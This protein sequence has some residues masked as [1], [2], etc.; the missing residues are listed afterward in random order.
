MNLRTTKWKMII[1]GLTAGLLESQ[2]T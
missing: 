1:R 2:N